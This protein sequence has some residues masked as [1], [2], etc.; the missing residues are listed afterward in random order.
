MEVSDEEMQ[1][2]DVGV[3]LTSWVGEDWIV[4]LIIP[5]WK[6]QWV[7]VTCLMMFSEGWYCNMCGT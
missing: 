2:N 3:G 4:M 7:E 1:D 5:L 6:R